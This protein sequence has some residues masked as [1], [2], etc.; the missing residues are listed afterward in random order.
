MLHRLQ[1]I[2][3][4]LSLIHTPD[5]FA[6]RESA[7]SIALNNLLTIHREII[8]GTTSTDDIQANGTRLINE[9]FNF[10]KNPKNKNLLDTP[11]GQDLL[12]RQTLLGNYMAVKAHFEKCVKDKKARRDLHSRVL[13]SSLQSMSRNDLSIFPC[14]VFARQSNNFINFNNQVMKTLK[15][16][17][18]EEA[19]K[20]LKDTIMTNGAR[21]LLNFKYKFDPAFTG[22]AKDIDNIA[23]MYNMKNKNVLNDY[24]LK[25]KDSPRNLNSTIIKDSLNQSIN[26]LK[27]SKTSEQF[28]KEV[29]TPAGALLLTPTM[30][31]RDK[32]ISESD[33][34]SIIKESEDQILSE[35]K[36]TAEEK[37]TD[38]LV[39]INPFASGEMLLSHPEYAGIVCDAINKINA[40]DT[41]KEKR[42]Q[43][44]MIGTAVLG[45]AL[46][47]TG[48][49]AMI[50]GYLITGSL[51]AGLVAGTVAGSLASGSAMASVVLGLGSALYEGGSAYQSHRE[52]VQLENAFLTNNGDGKNLEDA[53][54]ALGEFKKSRT[55][56]M[57]SLAS[58]GWNA[59]GFV[60]LFSMSQ[61]T[62][63]GFAIT[64]MKATQKIF[65]T[66]AESKVAIKLKS[67]MDAMGDVA[68][69]KVDTFMLHLAKA[70]EASRTKVLELLRDSRFTP[71]DLK[72]MMDE[73][74]IAAKNC[75]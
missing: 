44:V 4:I 30:R 43:Y 66:L 74:L 67:A 11:A 40:H 58:A 31:E 33:V 59:L 3:L 50:G 36:D 47:L 56:A 22:S 64:Q 68:M 19:N 53:K 5:V 6:K 55:D 24:F 29:Q 21:A 54:Q 52:M 28:L 26:R 38:G 9:T 17:V 35:K 75:T 49:G 41:S 14:T 39:K 65:D 34:A 15:K 61:L 46:V 7:N 32:P 10:I 57:I 23:K 2:V 63:K 70:G 13:D 60:K 71:K 42:D 25:I 51:S 73:A 48:V 20:T 72:E 62:S 45:G 16:G 18:S 1:L 69:A 8:S 37:T 12:R 27:I